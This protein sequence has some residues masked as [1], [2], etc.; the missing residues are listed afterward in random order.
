[1][2]GYT[3]PATGRMIPMAL[4]AWTKPSTKWVAQCSR[5]TPC[6]EIA[7][8]IK[9]ERRQ[10]GLDRRREQH[11]TDDRESRCGQKNNDSR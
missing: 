10:P 4:N 9:A 6:P 2:P 11:G 1:M 3:N 8:A 5:A 7:R